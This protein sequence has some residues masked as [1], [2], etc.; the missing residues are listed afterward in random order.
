MIKGRNSG[1]ARIYLVLKI[2]IYL[3]SFFPLTNNSIKVMFRELTKSNQ[4][5][6][7]E[8]IAKTFTGINDS[9]VFVFAA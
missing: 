9:F 5:V 8:V 6:R 7:D 3:F 2:Y 4:K 1:S